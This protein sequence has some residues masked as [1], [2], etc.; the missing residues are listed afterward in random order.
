[1]FLRKFWNFIVQFLFLPISLLINMLVLM[2]IAIFLPGGLVE[3]ALGTSAGNTNIILGSIL[4]FALGIFLC[5]LFA[6]L[7]GRK[8]DESWVST[9]WYVREKTTKIY[10]GDEQIGEFTETSEPFEESVT[11]K[12][13]TGWGWFAVITSFIAFPL[14]VIAFL[15]SF[16]ALFFDRVYSTYKSIQTEEY[17]NN[18]NLILHALFDFVIV[19][20][21]IPKRT[22]PKGLLFLLLYIVEFAVVN[23]GTVLVLG[24]LPDKSTLVTVVGF[25]SI[26]LF[27]IVGIL[28]IIKYTVFVCKNYSRQTGF[29]MAL[30]YLF[31]T[32]IPMILILLSYWFLG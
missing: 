17:Y 27:A 19:P 3:G 29:L 21:S 25:L 28:L 4:C 8:T 2:P 23:V 12:S 15:A 26:A 14:R 30:K 31:I 6:K 1:M 11:H 10:Y 16:V 22:N 9:A 32:L 7:K 5:K 13:L 20:V 24:T 18:G